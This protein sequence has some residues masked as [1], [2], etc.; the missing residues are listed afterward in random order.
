MPLQLICGRTHSGKSTYLM[1]IIKQYADNGKKLILVVPEQFAHIAEMRLLKKVGRILD[2]VIEITSFNRLAKRTVDM[3]D[4]MRD[5]VISSTA[6]SLVMSGVLR[7]TELEY[8]GNIS[9]EPGFV[10][11]CLETVS[12][13][14]KYNI[15]PDMQAAAAD[16]CDNELLAMKLRDFA[17]IREAYEQALENQFVDSDDLLNI[18]YDILCSSE[19]YSD[20][21]FF[22]DE[23]STF[24][25]QEERIITELVRR[26]PKVYMT[27]CMDRD[28]TDALF[29]PCVTTYNRL[30]DICRDEHI[31]LC[32]TIWL[33]DTFYTNPALSFAEKK[34]FSYPS[35]SYDADASGISIVKAKNPYSEVDNAARHI[36]ALVREHKLRYKDI[37]I[38][39]SDISRYNYIIY[40]VFS[41][42]DIPFFLDEKTAVLSHH[43][44]AFVLSI[45]DVYIN[46]YSYDSIFNF[47]KSGFAESDNGKISHLENF[48]AATNASKNLWLNDERWAVVLGNYAEEH[49]TESVIINEIREKYILPLSRFHESVKGR[50]SAKEAVALLYNYLMEIGLPDTISRY[51]KY[52]EKSGDIL[53]QKEYS[54]VW[55]VIVR[56]FD[57]IY[58]VIGDRKVNCEQLR[59]YLYVAFAHQSIG[60][61][62]TSVDRVTVGD[63]AR[64][65]TDGVK[66]VVVLGANEGVFPVPSKNTSM[67]SDKEKRILDKLGLS[68]STTSDIQAFYNQYLIYRAITMADSTL[69]V[70]YS[71][72]DSS[73]NT[74]SPSFT[75]ERLR[76]IFGNIV[77]ED[78]FE[79]ISDVECISGGSTAFENLITVV[80]K[81]RKGEEVPEFWK[82]VYSYY[83][84]EDFAKLQKALGYF[85]YTN[86]IRPVSAENVSLQVG[87]DMHT[88]VSRLQRYASCRYS[89]FLSYMLY[90]KEKPRA[91]LQS[92]DIGT[93][94][95]DI[96]EKICVGME[97]D[98]VTFD[99]ADKEYFRGKIRIMLDKYILRLGSEYA[100]LTRR[101]LYS[102]KRLEYVILL[103]F[104]TIQKQ[105]TDSKFVPMGYEIVFDDDNIGCIQIK[106]DDGRVLKL[107]GKIDRADVYSANGKN[108][109]RV[110]DYKTGTKSFNMTDVV[111]GID[112]QL[113]VYLSALVESSPDNMYGGAFFFPVSD[114]ILGAGN[115]M[116]DGEIASKLDS[117]TK[118][119]GI[120]ID[121]KE[122]LDAFDKI[123]VNRAGHKTSAEQFSALSA[124]LKKVIKDLWTDILRGNID[125]N[126]YKKG[127][128]TPCMY[129]PYGSVCRISSGNSGCSYNE[130]DKLDDKSAWNIIQGGEDSVDEKS[131]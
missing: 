113:L 48:I 65:R 64:T 57:E 18:L 39:C 108:Y 60:V 96:I 20:C 16:N 84:R 59:D 63:I 101:Q 2:D 40:N 102:I 10:D 118:M 13:F 32:D 19:L 25:P 52:F 78:T 104:E 5:S 85:K 3:T 35:V 62:P 71:T 89:Y 82:S 49:K 7:E 86:P 15:T 91:D 76:K 38:I 54:S 98:G 90:L 36:L 66:A 81:M 22:F 119:K 56:V 105:F 37:C 44:V 6:K 68:L 80:G 121:D 116:T 114:V 50:N 43:I 103:C 74:L 12:E 17:R 95:H 14:K 92:V 46:G 67:I 128:Y 1:D 73:Y 112:I 72:A 106:L 88:T 77:R 120:I 26:S 42:Y 47:I 55:D 131:E 79:D 41:R 27:L 99:T 28:L 115:N 69:Y 29:L 94:V 31:D 58:D 33:G 93:I 97:G 125:A 110:V 70:S 87:E 75:I 51:I 129:C 23:F 122:I 111:T 11:V 53:R 4:G 45:L 21:V 130:I 124:Y 123:T 9:K 61:I 8:Y 30:T 34:L 24:I 117:A 127:T 100:Q 83:T 109:L 126:P 107:T